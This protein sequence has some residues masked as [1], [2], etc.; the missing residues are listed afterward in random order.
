MGW[1]LYDNGL[2]HERFKQRYG[3]YKKSLNHEKHKTD[4]ELSNEYWELKN[5]KH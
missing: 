5:S 2:H 1:F 3:N 4:K